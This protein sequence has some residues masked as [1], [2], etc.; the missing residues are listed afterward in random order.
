MNATPDSITRRPRR[1]LCVNNDPKTSKSIPYGYLTGILY[2]APARLAGLG[3]VCP[4]STP[5]CQDACL[6]RAGRG[7]MT[8][9]QSARVR[10]TRE[11]FD[12]S[13]AFIS[14]LGNN[15]HA[16][17]HRAARLGLY[18]AIRLNGTSDIPWENLRYDGLSLMEWF[19]SVQFYDYS[20]SFVR[21]LANT[22]TNYHLTFS[23]TGDNEHTCKL[24]L[25]RGKNVAVVF[26]GDQFP[27]TYLGAPVL[28]GERS[29]LRFLDAPG[30]VIGLRA[31][32]P[33]RHTP[34]SF[35]VTL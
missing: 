4:N 5:E 21:V 33:A 6:Y 24:V 32:G 10:K 29:D 2:L 11:F 26:S 18:A 34:S 23:R 27:D 9:T 12:D 16:L 28:T 35:V 7:A 15:I 3:N 17:E 1:L 20:K 25:S 31:K 13:R 14:H 30:S 19:P 8:N 22:K